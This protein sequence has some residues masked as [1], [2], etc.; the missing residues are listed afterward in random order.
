M[1]QASAK[2]ILMASLML[3]AACGHTAS[4][5]AL[6]DEVLSEQ[7]LALLD[8]PIPAAPADLAQ[9][10]TRSFS[11]RDRALILTKYSFL[12]PDRVVPSK[13]LEKAV[14]YYD[15]NLANI[16]NKNVLSVID[17]SKSSS[18]VRFFVI[19]MASGKV[20]SMHV[21]HGKGS[22]KDHDGI[23]EK[24]SNVSGS[25]ASSL[26][27]YRTAETYIGRNGNSLRLDGLSSTNSNAR[28]RAIVIHGAD[29]V[30][31][32]DKIP[33][34]SAGCPA[35]THAYRDELIRQIKEGSIIYAGL[36]GS[37]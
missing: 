10:K 7:E 12:D 4:A 17:F 31:E 1:S 27:F 24:F 5:N 30:S 2:Y 3:S 37:K 6:P 13:L 20:W 26:G 18:K 28:D 23:A 8:G 11:A 19:D 32:E 9:L 14:L 15:S 25:N 22:D 34:R 21:T 36:S 35:V 33:G 29:Y 16:P